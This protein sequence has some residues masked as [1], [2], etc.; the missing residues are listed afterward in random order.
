MRFTNKTSKNKDGTFKVKLYWEDTLVDQCISTNNVEDAACM[1]ADA[2]LASVS[3]E[4]RFKGSQ[5]SKSQIT[6]EQ[7]ILLG[8]ARAEEALKF[9]LEANDM[10][11]YA[12]FQ[13]WSLWGMCNAGKT[14]IWDLL[15]RAHPF[16]I[17]QAVKAYSDTYRS[18]SKQV[19]K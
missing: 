18:V 1:M 15:M 16:L 7:A 3:K 11:K 19:A 10:P 9:L 17:R 6:I 5:H 13:D 2:M 12:S 8:P 4:L 14:C